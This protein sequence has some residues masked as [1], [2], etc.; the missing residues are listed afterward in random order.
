MRVFAAFCV[1]CALLAPRAGFA[2]SCAPAP[3]SAQAVA[4]ID[5]IFEGTVVSEQPAK[6]PLMRKLTNLWDPVNRYGGTLD[7]LVAYEFA[8]TKGWKGAKDGEIFIVIRNTSWGDR[9][10][11]DTP[12]LVFV[13]E[14]SPG[15]FMAG[16]CG[17]TTG[18][19]SEYG[20][21]MLAKLREIL[22]E[23]RAE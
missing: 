2:L 3:L 12:Y 18:I 13:N 16:I 1:I 9:F 17:H 8:V 7:D 11:A 5:V 10:T 14:E 15:V 4:G 20:R 19:D 6:L 21:N 22:G 23:D